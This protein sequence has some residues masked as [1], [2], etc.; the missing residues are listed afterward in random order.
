MPVSKNKHKFKAECVI[1]ANSPT[2]SYCY[3]YEFDG[4]REKLDINKNDDDTWHSL[5]L[6]KKVLINQNDTD[7]VVIK[8]YG[9]YCAIGDSEGNILILKLHQ[10][11]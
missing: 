1:L 9:E 6:K 10:L 8:A 5:T 4:S 3:M 2:K 7:L 11:E